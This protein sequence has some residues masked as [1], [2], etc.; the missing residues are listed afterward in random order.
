MTIWIDSNNQLHDDMN[1]QALTLPTWPSGMTIATQA[2]IDA[3]LN[4]PPTL[5]EAQASKTAE[6]YADYETQ[7][8]NN[9]TFTTQ[10]GVTQ[11]FQAT[12]TAINDIQGV[13]LGL[14]STKTVPSG[15]YWVAAD[16]T[17]VPFT[18]NDV[19][20]LA[21][22][23]MSLAWFYFQRLQ[24]QKAAVRAA[25]TVAEVNSVL[26]NGLTLPISGITSTVVLTPTLSTSIV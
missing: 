11:S 1:G 22:G 12:T 13:L 3:I 26:W 2:Q 9:F 15:F 23:I 5:T 7:I 21:N 8:S 4:P 18:Y 25:T 20:N 10:G 6:L 14:Q 24:A 16:N 19:Q 17:Q